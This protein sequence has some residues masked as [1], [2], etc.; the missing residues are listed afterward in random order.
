MP[1][2]A[3]V[4]VRYISPFSLWFLGRNEVL[5]EVETKR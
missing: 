1:I 5:I 3:P 2:V 4:Y